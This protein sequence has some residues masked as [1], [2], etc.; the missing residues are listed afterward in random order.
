[1]VLSII[2]LICRLVASLLLC[3]IILSE[4]GLI[5]FLFTHLSNNNNYDS[6]I[7]NNYTKIFK[8]GENEKAISCASRWKKVMTRIRNASF[9]YEIEEE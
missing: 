7:N 6:N 9:L 4:I 2:S 1:M 8:R 5:A 3:L